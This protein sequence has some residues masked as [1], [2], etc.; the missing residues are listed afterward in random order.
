MMT[1]PATPRHRRA[2]GGEMTM[3]LADQMQNMTDSFLHAHDL[4]A[5]A[6]KEIMEETNG[7]LGDTR[8]MMREVHAE[9]LENTETLQK[10]LRRVADTLT[11]EVDQAMK[12]LQ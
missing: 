6:L 9:R 8:K 5:N 7:D 3:G 11:K 2:N 10:T 4:R 1:F 12:G